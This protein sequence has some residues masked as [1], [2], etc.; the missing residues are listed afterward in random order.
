MER[1]DL[2]N[3]ANQ[4]LSHFTKKQAK[5]LILGGAFQLLKE[6]TISA[7]GQIMIHESL[8]RKK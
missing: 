1:D 4:A 7:K 6:S 3:E 8:A 5:V 2:D